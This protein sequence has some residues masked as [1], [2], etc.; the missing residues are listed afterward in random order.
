[1]L[2]RI[3]TTAAVVGALAA[4]ILAAP[5]LAIEN[6]LSANVIPIG[7]GGVHGAVTF[8]QLGSNVNVGLNLDNDTPGTAAVD[9]RKGTCKNYA[10]NSRWP[11]GTFNGSSQE[12]RLPNTKLESLM[13]QVLL[14][15]KTQSVD[16][17]VIG[18]AEIH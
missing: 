15:H 5:A 13:G 9:L 7:S 1:M 4:S 14:V 18:C 8:F 2:T 11:L 12:T 16:S 6:P 3:A 17:P 10:Q